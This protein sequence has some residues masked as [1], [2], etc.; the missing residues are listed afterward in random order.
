MFF[1]TVFLLC[2]LGYGKFFEFFLHRGVFREFGNIFD[3]EM[4]EKLEGRFIVETAL[5]VRILHPL[6]EPANEKI[7]Q[8]KSGV[9]SAD[10]VDIGASHW[11]AVENNGECF[12][13]SLTEISGE[14][15][16]ADFFYKLAC[17]RRGAKVHLI[18]FLKE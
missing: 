7:A 18:V 9:Y 5:V 17:F 16:F 6:N 8:D 10:V 1:F 2:F 13:A 12:R 15:F 11:I 4:R 3:S 14:L